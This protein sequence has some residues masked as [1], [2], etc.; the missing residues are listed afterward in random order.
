MAWEIPQ[1]NLGFKV[2]RSV[3]TF[4]FGGRGCYTGWNPKSHFLWASAQKDEGVI[5]VCLC[6]RLGKKQ[7]LTFSVKKEKTR[8]SEKCNIKNI[9]GNPFK[10]QYDPLQWQY[11]ILLVPQCA[12]VCAHVKIMPLSPCN[13]MFASLDK[14]IVRHFVACAY[15]CLSSGNQAIA[16]QKFKKNLQYQIPS[17]VKEERIDNRARHK[18]RN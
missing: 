7:Y 15:L 1:P 9:G 18:N 2:S 4:C 8:V 17:L 6:K 11:C 12:R 10:P 14:Q 16:T 5:H 3:V 13:Q